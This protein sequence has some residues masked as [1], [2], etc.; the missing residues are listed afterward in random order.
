M[1]H[2]RGA[3]NPHVFQHTLRLLVP[4]L[5]LAPAGL[6]LRFVPGETLLRSGGMRLPFA[7]DGFFANSSAATGLG[8]AFQY[9]GQGI[10][11]TNA[12]F[13]QKAQYC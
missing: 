5:G 8:H 3:R 6:A 11:K 12:L 1:S 9:P 13:Q 10:R 7:P 4:S 2:S